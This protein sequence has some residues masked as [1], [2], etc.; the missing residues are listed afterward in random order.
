MKF[1]L[2][3][4]LIISLATV[5]YA[6]NRPGFPIPRVEQEFGALIPHLRG[7]GGIIKNDP[8]AF[9]LAVLP[10]A[11]LDLQ[12]TKAQNYEEADALRNIYLG[13]AGGITGIDSGELANSFHC[14]KN[15]ID[16]RKTDVVGKLSQITQFVVEFR[17][18]SQ[19]KIL[20]NWGIKEEYRVNNVFHMMGQTSES[21]PSPIMGFIPSDKWRKLETVEKYLEEIKVPKA[22]FESLLTKVKEMSLAAVVGDLNGSVRVVRVGIGDNEAGLLFVSKSSDKPSKGQKMLDGREYVYVEEVKPN[23]FY[24]ETT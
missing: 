21:L 19:I 12:I 9:A 24:Y 15:C 1:L 3:L 8:K 17:A 23:V 22:K 18:A 7:V 6:Q 13:V 5:D 10:Y 2:P 4:A 16:Y 20:A 14:G 11:P